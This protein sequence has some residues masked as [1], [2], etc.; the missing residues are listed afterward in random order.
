MKRTQAHRHLATRAGY[1]LAA[2]V[3]AVCLASPAR[4]IDLTLCEKDEL[5]YSAAEECDKAISERGHGTLDRGRVYTLRGYAWMREGEP[6]GAVAD[7]SRA[8][9]L[10]A[11]NIAA[12]KGRAHA[13]TALKRHDDAIA[14]WTS[15]IKLRPDGEEHYRERAYTYLEMGNA[16]EAFADYDKAIEIKAKNPESYVG[17]AQI[18]QRLQMREAAL[19]EFDKAVASDPTYP[20]T[21]FAKAQAAESWGDAE[22]AIQSYALVVRYNG[23]VWYA[24]R[25]MKRLGKQ[26]SDLEAS[27]STMPRKSQ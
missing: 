8:I 7:F 24:Q 1:Y 13:F 18:Y 20:N 22:L 16:K 12:L 15:I 11:T 19:R 9:Q 23:N 17:R 21:Y 6:G 5:P 27:E 25:A 4:A 2:A 10:D 3:S 14:D 26:F